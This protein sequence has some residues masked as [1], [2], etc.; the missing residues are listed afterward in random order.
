MQIRNT[1][2]R[3]VTLGVGIIVFGATAAM[4]T[5]YYLSATATHE[6]QASQEISQSML[7]AAAGMEVSTIASG[8][9]VFTH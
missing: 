3:K 1:I 4:F 2:A 8:L 5:T 6:M 7:N 9:Q